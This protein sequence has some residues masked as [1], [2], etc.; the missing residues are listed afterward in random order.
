MALEDC[1]IRVPMSAIASRLMV[2]VRVRGLTPF[3][4][5]WWIAIQLIRLGA[6]IAGCELEIDLRDARR[7]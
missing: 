6:L 4:I 1:E 7:E 5:R 3:A 2:T